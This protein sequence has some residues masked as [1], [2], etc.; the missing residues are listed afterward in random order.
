MQV[1]LTCPKYKGRVPY[2]NKFPH[3]WTHQTISRVVSMGCQPQRLL[4]AFTP[5]RGQKLTPCLPRAYTVE[6]VSN[7]MTAS[8][9]EGEGV[10]HTEQNRPRERAR[11]E[12]WQG[13]EGGREIVGQ[14]RF[15]L[16]GLAAENVPLL[17]KWLRGVGGGPMLLFYYVLQRSPKAG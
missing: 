14:T 13:E 9:W 10:T 15:P 11:E 4:K 7:C 2:A 17:G 12:G 16:D 1:S 5:R 3:D 6:S 8:Q